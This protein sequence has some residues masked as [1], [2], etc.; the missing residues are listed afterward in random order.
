[1]AAA[2]LGPAPRAHLRG[3]PENHVID[4]GEARLA[5]GAGFV[6]K[7]CGGIMAMP[8]LPEVPSADKID[9]LNGRAVGLF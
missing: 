3:A 4:V 5:A 2:R 9:L 8:G 7:V 1:M 6:V